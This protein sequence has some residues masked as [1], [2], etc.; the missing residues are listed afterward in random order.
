MCAIYAYS[1]RRNVGPALTAA[2]DSILY[3]AG[4]LF[5]LRAREVG[6]NMGH[7]HLEAVCFFPRALWPDE[8]L[9]HEHLRGAVT[10]AASEHGVSLLAGG[11]LAHNP[12]KPL[13]GVPAIDGVHDRSKYPLKVLVVFLFLAYVEADLLGGAPVW[14]VIEDRGPMH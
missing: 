14:Q 11:G 6:P 4:A 7:L 9:L 3:R 5:A 1:F 2:V 13:E 10:L 12:L 8:T